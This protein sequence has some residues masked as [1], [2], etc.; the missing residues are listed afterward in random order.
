M[1][2][3]GQK[4]VLDDPRLRSY[5]YPG[6][7]D[8]AIPTA[9]WFHE[10]IKPAAYDPTLRIE[11]HMTKMSASLM[12]VP[13]NLAMIVKGDPNAPNSEG[14]KGSGILHCVRTGT[15]PP[16]PVHL[17]VYFMPQMA[18]VE[19]EVSANSIRKE[20]RYDGWISITEDLLRRRVIR[21]TEPIKMLLGRN[22]S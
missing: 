21:L 8:R 20:M 16:R 22:G 15:I 3:D 6:V 12:G 17:D 11:T 9:T 19:D 2:T 7:R 18:P 13:E 1:L 5:P 10:F 14:F 4:Q